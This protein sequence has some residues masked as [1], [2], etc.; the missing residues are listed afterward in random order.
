MK[1]KNISAATNEGIKIAKGDFIGFLDHDDELRNNTLLQVAEAVNNNPNVKFIYTD[2]DKIDMDGNRMDPFFKPDW[3][4]DLILSQNYICHFL[5]IEKEILV[6][7]GGFDETLNGCQDWD[8]I[9]ASNR[10]D[11]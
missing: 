3:N 5:C 10:K 4:P 2:E 11:C 7:V 9:L 1:N 6:D 8:V